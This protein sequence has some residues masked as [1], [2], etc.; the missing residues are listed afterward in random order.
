M[1]NEANKDAILVLSFGTTYKDSRQ[2][3]IDRTVDAIKAAHPDQKVVVAFTSHII[4]DRIKA[5]EGLTVPTPEQAMAQLKKKAIRA[6]PLRPSTS[7]PAWNTLMTRLF[8][9]SIKR[10]SKNDPRHAVDV[11]DGSGRPAR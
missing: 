8:S 11:L 9:T 6:W 10:I 7:S 2:K 5:K 1:Q 4:V 3:T